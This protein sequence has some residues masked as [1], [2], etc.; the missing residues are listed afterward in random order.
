MFNT[1]LKKASES[2]F[3]AMASEAMDSR[4]GSP[5]TTRRAPGSPLAQPVPG[6]PARKSRNP[7]AAGAGTVNPHSSN[8]QL[9][10]QLDEAYSDIESFQKLLQK[11]TQ[12]KSEASGLIVKDADLL[13]QEK[14]SIS[15]ELFEAR[16]LIKTMRATLEAKA[17]DEF[18][19]PKTT[20]EEGIMEGPKPAID[21][22]AKETDMVDP[23]GATVTGQDDASINGSSIKSEE[24]PRSSSQI[25]AAN[26]V[27]AATVDRVKELESKLT[28]KDDQCKELQATL[29][30][31]TKELGKQ[32]SDHEEKMKKMKAIF[33]A[34]NKNLNEYRQS[35]AAK[36][37]EIAELKTRMES[38]PQ[39]EASAEHN[40]AMLDLESE[41]KSQSE[42][43]ASKLA[44]MESKYKQTNAQLEKL[45]VEYQQYKQRAS[46][47]LQQQRESQPTDDDSRMSE[48]QNQL[49][50]LIKENKSVTRELQ[51]VES[52]KSS[53]E[54]ELQLAMDQIS[55]LESS[56]EINRRQERQYTR[57][58]KDLE[59]SLKDAQS[60][61]ESVEA[62]LASLQELR[63]METQSMMRELGGTTK[64]IEERL[65]KK[66]EEN[67]ELHRILDRSSDELAAAKQE[68]QTLRDLVSSSESQGEAALV[69]GITSP[70]MDDPEAKNQNQLLITTGFGPRSSFS[71]HDI[72]SPI[73]RASS[74]LSLPAERPPVY[75]TLS[76][77]LAAKPLVERSPFAETS[78]VQAPL[79]LLPAKEKEYQTKL[80]HLTDL[81]NE[82]EA[83][84]QRLLDQAKVLKE[85]IRNLDRAERRQ[86]L[87][88]DYLKN[89]VLKYLET[90]DKEQLLPVLTTVLQLS[91]AEVAS[92]KKKTVQPSVPS[93]LGGFFGGSS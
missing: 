51:E 83:N 46:M 25:Y 30:T 26:G 59:R 12:E 19:S 77:L 84:H 15:E 34:A 5:A 31:R 71:P 6:S 66:E 24:K 88:V 57:Q 33:A 81:L 90:P 14:E 41:L 65:A 2:S 28:E 76:D 54:G 53:V 27:D 29:T 7:R 58:L 39:Q 75:S 22:P 73:S 18:L 49:D 62:R 11:A 42:L 68:I 52:K 80:Q 91:P 45:R 63:D 23:L 92:L 43:A 9:A 82:S 1:L 17:A 61:R 37:E 16:A 32:K 10:S 38:Q 56:Q 8:A 69:A 48:L 72:E 4:P 47:L 89:I 74:S 93:V 70:P 3:A 20:S 50:T 40:Q 86:N 67:A 87:S 44:Q 78:S 35:I 85:E 64:H 79:G 21:T 60:E 36:D 55:S 13:R